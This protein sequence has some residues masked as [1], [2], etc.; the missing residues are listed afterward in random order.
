MLRPGF[1]FDAAILPVYFQPYFIMPYPVQLLITQAECDEALTSLNLE[2]RVFTVNDQVLDLRADQASDRATDRATEV[3]NLT[4]EVADLTALVPTL[5]PGTPTHTYNS[6]RL[7]TASRRL[8]DLGL[9]SGT[10]ARGPQA[11]LRA[12]DVR[13]VQ[14]QVPELQAAIAEVTDHRATLRA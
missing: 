4:Q 2:L 12:V 7:R 13:Q 8:E 3:Q 5:T 10:A 6:R 1:T 14:V 11:F 9:P